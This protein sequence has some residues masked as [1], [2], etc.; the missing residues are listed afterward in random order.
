MYYISTLVTEH[1]DGQNKENRPAKRQP[2]AFIL[3]GMNYASYI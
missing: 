1:V 2:L 3:F